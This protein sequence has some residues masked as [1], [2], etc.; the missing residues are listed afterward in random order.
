MLVPLLLIG[1][2]GGDDDDEGPVSFRPVANFV[3]AGGVAEIVA[4]TPDGNTLIYTDADGRRIGF[5]DITNPAPSS[6]SRA[7]RVNGRCVT[8]T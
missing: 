1:C 4:A 7:S 8:S 6:R 3:I 2:G 5:V